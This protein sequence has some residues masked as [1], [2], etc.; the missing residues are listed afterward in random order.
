MVSSKQRLQIRGSP[1][2]IFLVSTLTPTCSSSYI[3]VTLIKS[4]FGLGGGGLKVDIILQDA[5]KPGQQQDQPPVPN[6]QVVPMHHTPS[7][8]LRKNPFFRVGSTVVPAMNEM[9]VPA[10]C[11]YEAA[12]DVGGK[13]VL[14]LPPGKKADHLGIKIQFIGR[15][16]MVRTLLLYFQHVHCSILG[17]LVR[18]SAGWCGASL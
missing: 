13:I 4:F 17:V 3:V 14:T 12:Q 16:D 7:W 2:R 6:D 15:I 18:S 1:A 8:K 9:G 10:I 5:V 11:A